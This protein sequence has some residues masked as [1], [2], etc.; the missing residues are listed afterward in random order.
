MELHTLSHME[1]LLI[2]EG[3]FFYAIPNH[4]DTLTLLAW[5]LLFFMINPR[6]RISPWYFIF[7]PAF[8]I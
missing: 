6:V 1:P 5:M 3:T 4:D 8:T 7:T 2:N